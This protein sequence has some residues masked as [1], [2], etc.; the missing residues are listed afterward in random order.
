[1]LSA[2]GSAD[3]S[4]DKG[5]KAKKFLIVCAANLV[6]YN[7][8]PCILLQKNLIRIRKTATNGVLP[9][10]AV[11]LFF[12][13]SAVADCSIGHNQ[14]NAAHVVLRLYRNSFYALSIFAQMSPKLAH[15]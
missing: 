1:M 11:F 5:K 6:F 15:L 2:V 9:K 8:L 4:F 7:G 3:M 12:C 14:L 10:V 13:C